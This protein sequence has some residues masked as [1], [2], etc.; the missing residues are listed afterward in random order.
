VR[1]VRSATSAIAVAVLLAACGGAQGGGGTSSVSAPA[2]PA[3]TT[4]PPASLGGTSWTMTTVGGV[5][6]KPGGLLAFATGR[7]M[8]GSTG[9]NDFAGTYAQTGGAL[10][11][12]IGPVT[13][14]GCPDLAAQEA[15]VLAALPRTASFSSDG[16]T[17][18]LL[19]GSGR[20]LLGYRHVDATSLVGPAWQVTGI[21]N[22]RQAVSSVIVGSTVTATFAA[23][24]TVS[25]SAGCNSYSAPYT[26]AGDT[27]KVQPAAAT[28]KFCEAPDGVME[29]ESAFLAALERSTSVETVSSGVTLRDADG[30][31]QL[32]LARPG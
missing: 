2:A 29:Q 4:A 6:A 24:G 9:C 5:T 3:A 18:T 14:K 23:D 1:A 32:T 10:A 26:L 8:T 28:R 31:T 27:L 21:N 11:I 15:A 17:L 30:S 19:D 12:T 7:E 13:A 20:E 22:G 16:R 25:G